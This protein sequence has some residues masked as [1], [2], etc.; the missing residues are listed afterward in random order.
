MCFNDDGGIDAEEMGIILGIT[1]EIEEEEKSKLI[2]NEPED[3]SP[4][5]LEKEGIILEE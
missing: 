2:D 3:I 1:D 4:D 5:T